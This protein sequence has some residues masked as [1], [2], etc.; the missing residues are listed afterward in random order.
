LD[1]SLLVYAASVALVAGASVLVFV[2]FGSALAGRR[3]AHGA[4]LAGVG[5]RAGGRAGASAGPGMSVRPRIMVTTTPLTPTPVAI[6][7]GQ[8]R[9]EATRQATMAA[10]AR[11]ARVTSQFIVP[12]ATLTPRGADDPRTRSVDADR[13][14]GVGDPALSTRQAALGATVLTDPVTGV[15]SMAVWN[16]NLAREDHR[17]TRYRRPVTVVLAELDGL[18]TVVALMGPA[19]ADRLIGPVGAAL[20]RGA[21][22]SDLVARIGEARFAILL[23]ETDEVAATNYAERVRAACDLWLAAGRSSVRL[24]MGWAMPVPGSHL[25]DAMRIAAERMSA[26]R[27]RADFRAPV[28]FPEPLP[29]TD[30]P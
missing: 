14:A 23:P 18:E 25:A 17:F 1:Q 19:A 4:G 13:P 12:P 11:D 5:G 6:A 30:H 22:V 8:A 24:A 29:R 7:S 15:A 26:D 21:R 9:A 27:R 3:S 20:R 28:A 16:E 2:T 10:G